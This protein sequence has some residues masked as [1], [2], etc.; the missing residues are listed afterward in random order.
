[1]DFAP[2]AT[3]VP[4]A[5]LHIPARPASN[6]SNGARSWSSGEPTALGLE[7][8]CLA[9]APKW[10]TTA[11]SVGMGFADSPRCQ[12]GKCFTVA[13]EGRVQLVWQGS[14]ERASHCCRISDSMSA[15]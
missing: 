3:T 4:G 13:L 15:T 6:G 11:S 2:T 5:M 1:M 14:L 7:S 8:F 12:D 10:E 9:L